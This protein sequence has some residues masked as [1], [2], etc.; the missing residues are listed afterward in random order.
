MKAVGINPWETYA[1]AGMFGIPS[2]TL[3]RSFGSD[4]AGIVVLVGGD[5]DKLKVIDLTLLFCVGIE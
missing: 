5:V 2:E 1:R 4:C 3:P